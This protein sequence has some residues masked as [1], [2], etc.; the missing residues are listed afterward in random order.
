K[1]LG[2]DPASAVG[3]KIMYSTGFGPSATDIQRAHLQ[4]LVID[5]VAVKT[6]NAFDMSD[7]LIVSDL[8]L[9]HLTTTGS[10]PQSGLLVRVNPDNVGALQ[11][12][13]GTVTDET[14]QPIFTARRIDQS[15]QLAPV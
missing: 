5:G 14:G 2:F 8:P 15:Q 11:Q 12:M 13:I 7:I 1:N 9:P 3:Q 4:P 6:S 10:G